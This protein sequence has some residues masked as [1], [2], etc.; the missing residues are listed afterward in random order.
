MRLMIMGIL[1]ACAAAF[2]AALVAEQFDSTFH[3][4]DDIREFTQV[5]VLGAIAAIT[6]GR[7]RRAVRL[8]AATASVLVLIAIVVALSAHAA[9][10]NEQIVWL[11]ARS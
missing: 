4:V 3:T 2:I 1:F 10:G 7:T 8:V 9:K 6:P 5:P 11:L